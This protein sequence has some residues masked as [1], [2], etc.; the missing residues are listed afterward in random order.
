MFSGHLDGRLPTDDEL[1]QDNK[2]VILPLEKHLETRSIAGE[3]NYQR[4]RSVN[5][6]NHPVDNIPYDCSHFPFCPVRICKENCQSAKY[7]NKYGVSV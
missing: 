5:V 1:Q 4:Q 6:D 7:Y 3:E 2:D